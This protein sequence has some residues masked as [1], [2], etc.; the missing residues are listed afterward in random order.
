VHD[1]DWVKAGEPLIDGSINPHSILEILGPT[2]LQRYLVDE[3][4][5]VYRLQGVSIHDKHIEVIVTQM[6][7]KVRVEDPGDT[8]S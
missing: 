2:E 4:Q 7:K 8:S 3:I 6:M 5:K 1:G